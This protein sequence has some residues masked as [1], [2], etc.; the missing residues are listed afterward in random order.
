MIE[1][2][3]HNNSRTIFINSVEYYIETAHLIRLEDTYYVNI[4]DQAVVATAVFDVFAFN[5]ETNTFEYFP[6]EQFEQEMKDL[7]RLTNN[8]S[9]QHED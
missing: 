5:Y 1:H 2:K 3:E 8:Q 6:K 7:Q 4:A 9:N